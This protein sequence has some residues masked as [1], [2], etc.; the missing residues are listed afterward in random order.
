[1][2]DEAGNEVKPVAS[3]RFPHSWSGRGH[4][5]APDEELRLTW[6]GKE[7]LELRDW[8]YELTMA[9]KYRIAGDRIFRGLGV[10]PRSAGVSSNVAE[11]TN[12]R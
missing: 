12:E 6:A 10:P 9:G 3:P 5:L 11:V 1:V 4:T 8:G 2:Y 7:W